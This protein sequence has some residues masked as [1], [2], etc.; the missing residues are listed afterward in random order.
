M[1]RAVKPPVDKWGVID[2][3]MHKL[4]ECLGSW[5]LGYASFWKMRRIHDPKPKIFL[6]PKYDY[7]Y[8]FQKEKIWYYNSKKTTDF[9]I[10]GQSGERERRVEKS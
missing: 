1:L 9:S 6:T 7:N 8:F 3:A 4:K 5:F 2:T 10:M